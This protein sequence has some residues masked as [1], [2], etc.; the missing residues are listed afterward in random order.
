MVTPKLKREVDVVVIGAGTAGL[1][2]VAELRKSQRSW[3]LVESG[4][5]GTTCARVGC[6]PSKLLVAAAD[7]AHQVA[8][9]G[10]FGISAGPMSVD[11]PA[12]FGRVRAERDRFVGGVIKSTEKLPAEQRL[13]GRARLIG[14]TRVLVERDGHDAVEL[15][16]K[17]VVAAVGSRSN[18]P[19]PFRDIMQ[20]VWLSDEVFELNQLP[21]SLAVIGTGAI[22]LELGQALSRLGVKVSF[23]SID[24]AIGPL[25]DP[26]LQ[27]SVRQVFQDSSATNALAWHL[28]V[29]IKKAQVS[30]SDAIELEW[31][32]AAGAA[33][34]QSF[35]NVL[36][37]AGR[38]PQLAELGLEEA[39]VILN[40]RGLPANWDPSTT[41][42][43]DTA[44]F[45]AGDASHYRPI[46]HEAADEGRVAGQNAAQYPQVSTLVRRTPLAI[47]F[48]QPQ[49]ATVGARYTDLD[50]DEIAIG[51]V[52]YANQG[53]ARVQNQHA[54]Q[55]NLYAQRSSCVLVGAE[56]FCPGAEHL[57]HLL[58]WA[59]QQQL[60]V[61]E[62]L[63]MPFYHPVLE[64]GLRTA[65]WSLSR[66][67]KIEGKC[68]GADFA[69][70]AGV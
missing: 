21:E 34:Q 49:M 15:Q 53:R 28:D 10:T 48:T 33:H 11:A 17:A 44:V 40:E 27:H 31:Q 68:R 35:S 16:T 65:L 2:A 64:E 22:G 30:D 29:D 12:L 38:T 6:M 43:G 24:S 61:E 18:I 37:A 47:V 63:R 19:R 32:D 9:A 52:S 62:L 42:C 7:R 36:L 51:T 23:F 4:P 58:A 3:V 66:A 1:N 57:A 45:I 5:Y 41:R 69:E 14:P 25:R 13:R 26:A 67:L 59:V 20:R 55:V 8:T 56:L 70:S 50:A 54:G 46:L 60:R 39:G